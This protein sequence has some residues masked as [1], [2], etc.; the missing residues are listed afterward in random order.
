MNGRGIVCV[1][2]CRVSR[3]LYVHVLRHA[4]N[5]TIRDSFMGIENAFVVGVAAAAVAAA[6]AV[7]VD[8]AVVV[9]VISLCF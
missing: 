7:A 6:V 3:F 9:I 5:T 1:R 2:Q 4:K 8:V